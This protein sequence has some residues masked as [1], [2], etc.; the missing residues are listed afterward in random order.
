MGIVAVVQALRAIVHNARNNEDAQ[1]LVCIIDCI[2]GCIQD[3]LEYF[4]KWAYVYV[5]LYGFG[6]IEAGRNVI[7]LFKQKGW[8]VIIS[9]DLNERVFLMMSVSVGI[10]TGIIGVL[11]TMIDESLVN[12]L[13]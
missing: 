11:A 8:S 1:L 9:D 10:L 6:Y 12:D 4:N 13:D 3:I 2:L 5:G 7:E